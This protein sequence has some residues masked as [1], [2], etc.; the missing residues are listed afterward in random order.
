MKGKGP[1]RERET[2]ISFNEEEDTAQ[3]WTASEPMYRKLRKKGYYPSE[4]NERSATF[5][6]PKK[7]VSIRKIKVLTE[8]Q[9]TT[10]TK[11]AGFMRNALINT[12]EK[13]PNSSE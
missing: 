9:K 1:R 12:R 11:R 10:L 8:K 6:V 13:A 2:T 7:Q 5:L 3:V 4:D